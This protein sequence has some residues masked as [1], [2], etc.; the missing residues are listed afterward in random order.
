LVAC[1]I[2]WK[3]IR[4]PGPLTNGWL[5][6]FGWVTSMKIA[7]IHDYQPNLGGTTEVVIRIARALK[8]RGHSCKLIT[9]P[10]SWVKERDK[11]TMELVYAPKL[12][13]TFMKYAPH[14]STKVGEI[15]SLYDRKEIDLC[16]AHYVLPYGLAAYLAKQVCGIPYI[17]TLHGTDI[18]TLASMPSLKPVMKLCL[19]AAD[20]V[21]SVCEYLRERAVEKLGVGRAITLIPNFVDVGQFRGRRGRGALRAVTSVCEYLRERAA[22]R[23]GIHRA[24]TVVPN[25]VGLGRFRAMRG[26]SELKKEFG[27]PRGYCVVAHISNY[28]EI[29][30]TLV[31]PDIAR[32]VVQKHL[33][34]LFMMVGEPLGEIGY[35]LEKLKKTVSHLGLDS[36]FRFVGRRSD[37]A[38]ILHLSDISLLTSLNEAAPLAVLESLAAGVPVVCSMVGGVPELVRHGANG[39][40]VTGQS[41]GEYA[42][43]ISRLIENRELRRRMGMRGMELIRKKYSEEVVM[44]QYLNLYGSVHESSCKRNGGG[45]GPK[46][47]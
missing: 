7:L 33:R 18:H 3:G 29:K 20:A 16:H 36:H 5:A 25:F 12:E 11:E 43:Y 30:N 26:R 10:E 28:A 45:V 44:P 24:I 42:A 32:E 23:L 1:T 39:Y 40:L 2:S 41:V 14:I 19:E 31:I 15:V 13:I 9:Y 17:M 22:E 6:S 8:K 46:E 21:T 38:R 47:T 35:D 34:T 37:V 4:S 27:I